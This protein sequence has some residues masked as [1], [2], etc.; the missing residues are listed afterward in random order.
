MCTAQHGPFL[1]PVLHRAER[2]S[3]ITAVKGQTPGQH[4]YKAG[5]QRAL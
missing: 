5:G 4:M 1:L 3:N 2:T